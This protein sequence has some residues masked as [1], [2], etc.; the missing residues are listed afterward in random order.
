[1]IDD[2]FKRYRIKHRDRILA[3]RRLRYARRGQSEKERER[4]YR[5]VYG[6]TYR[7]EN[8]KK[9]QAYQEVYRPA[10]KEKHAKH[11]KRWYQEN[12]EQMLAKCKARYDALSPEEKL[13]RSRQCR[14]QNIENSRRLARAY[15]ERSKDT[16]VTWSKLN[17]EKRREVARNYA[18]R[19]L[20]TP[21]GRLNGRMSTAIR[22]ALKHGKN[23]KRWEELVGYTVQDL[24]RHI[25]VNFKPGMNWKRFLNGEIHIDHVIPKSKFSYANH[26]DPQFRQCW[27]L[28]NLDQWARPNLRKSAKLL[29]PEQIPLGI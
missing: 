22:R 16:R 15:Y 14:L 20:A 9:I 24:R 23:G 12:K 19:N 1:M 8:K 29:K 10:H 6:R 7:S 17:P 21:K 28:E 18:R 26:T 27:A 3:R 11:S 25:E 4:A 2:R 13:K 5:N